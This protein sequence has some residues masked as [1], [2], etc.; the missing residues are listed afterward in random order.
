MSRLIPILGWAA[1]VLIL[2]LPAGAV[3]AHEGQPPV[4][5]DLWESWNGAPAFVLLPILWLY[6]RGFRILRHRANPQTIRWRT[7]FFL[8]GMGGLFLAFVSPVDAW[9]TALF[10]AHMLQHM[11]LTLIVSPLLILG[12]PFGPILL[13]LPSDVRDQVGKKWHQLQ[14]IRSIGLAL[15]L[16]YTAWGLHVLVFWVWHIPKFYE[17]ALTR[18]WVHGFEHLSFLGTGL[19]FWWTILRPSLRSTGA[20]ADLGTSVFSL[21]TMAVQGGFLGAL[22]IFAPTP[23]YSSYAETTQPWGLTPLEDQQLAGAI[24]WIPAGVGYTVAALILLMRHLVRIEQAAR[25]SEARTADRT[26]KADLS[27]GEL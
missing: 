27:G 16:P 3:D 1:G 21:F 6:F 10:S 19:L 5:H 12:V 25:R 26:A 11:C 7:G 14:G 24:M 4:P 8:A 22:L 2:L 17:T 15:T 23:W 13:G 9:S 20:G 18:V